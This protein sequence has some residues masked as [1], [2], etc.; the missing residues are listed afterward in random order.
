MMSGMGDVTAA[1]ATRLAATASLV[2]LAAGCVSEFKPLGKS[3][4]LLPEDEQVETIH[5][6]DDPDGT[7]L[8]AMRSL[9]TSFTIRR[10][11]SIPFNAV[12]L[13]LASFDG[14]INIATQRGRPS[15][16]LFT[17]RSVLGADTA[18][19]VVH[20][21]GGPDG[22]YEVFESEPGVLLGRNGNQSG[23]LVERPNEDGSR[24]IGVLS[25]SD[26]SIDWI[27]DDGRVNAFGWIDESG[28]VVY[29]TRSPEDSEFIIG[30]READGSRWAIDETL[31]YSWL[32]PMLDPDGR[33]LFAVRLG[34]GYADMVYGTLT[35]A[36]DFRKSMQIH[37]MSNRADSKRVSQMIS[38]TTF[39]SESSG[40]QIPWYSYELGRMVVWDVKGDTVELL[41]EDSVAA[42]PLKQMHNWLVTTPDGLDRA[43]LFVSEPVQD[44]LI[45]FPWLARSMQGDD[46][47]IVEPLD[48]MIEIAVM[49]LGSAE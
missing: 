22:P 11:G 34:D 13:P 35:N 21:L 47:L 6:M 8:T 27:L 24:S 18:S 42:F 15:S 43:A 9:S 16:S 41:P 5:R 31:P 29:S 20:R 32:Y 33:S 2:A 1:R 36:G 38:T 26:G 28:R 44:R 48:R 17:A 45:D 3:Q 39:G 49:T 23:F 40:S 7:S 19:V 30:V 37:R 10:L 46:I 25:W 4:L 12:N 14:G